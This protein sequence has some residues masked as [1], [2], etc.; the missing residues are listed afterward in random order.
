MKIKAYCTGISFA[1]L[2]SGSNILAQKQKIHPVG[3]IK[4]KM[5]IPGTLVFDTTHIYNMTIYHQVVV[6]GADTGI[7]TLS[8]KHDSLEIRR[9]IRIVPGQ[10]DQYV[11]RA[12]SVFLKSTVKGKVVKGNKSSVHSYYIPKKHGLYC[13]AT[14]GFSTGKRHTYFNGMVVAGYQVSPIFSVGGG[15]GYVQQYSS[16]NSNVNLIFMSQK[17]EN[18][19]G[20]CVQYIPL[21][22]DIR[23]NLLR[24]KA[25]PY[26]S[27]DLGCSFPMPVKVDGTYSEETMFLGFTSSTMYKFHIDNLNP[28]FFLAINPGLKIFLFRH[29]YLDLSL[30]VDMSF[31][32]I[33]GTY[34]VA[35]P[36]GID[37]VVNP[38]NM[39]KTFS[40][41]HMNVGFGF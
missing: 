11:I 34:Q 5:E 41:F 1:V 10:T 22:V 14:I 3:T 30:G 38:I 40:C 35:L 12:D 25:T 27:I 17:I 15:I 26:F 24:K 2:F 33:N 31:N 13:L 19:T 28:G 37:H 29:Y 4:V 9:K 8:L 18:A 23:L 16:F 21:F 6:T 20:F 39:T 7:H 36:A 32:K